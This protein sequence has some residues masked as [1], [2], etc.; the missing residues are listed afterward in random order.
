VAWVVDSASQMCMARQCGM[1]FSLFTR[2]HHCR[3]CGDLF[4]AACTP[5]RQTLRLGSAPQR[6][7]SSCFVHH[8][9]WL[10]STGPTPPRA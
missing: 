4:C 6:V 7:C 8:E 3:V 2:R 1:P 10:K 9:S 5:K